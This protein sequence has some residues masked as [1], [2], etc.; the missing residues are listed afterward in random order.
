M[1]DN[2]YSINGFSVYFQGGKMQQK[3][4]SR[5]WVMCNQGKTQTAHDHSSISH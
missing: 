2:K 4:T 1:G 5:K 3:R